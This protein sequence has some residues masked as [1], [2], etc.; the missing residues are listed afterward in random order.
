MS[1]P[2]LGEMRLMPFGF[3]PRGW[4]RCDGGILPINQNTALFSLLGTTYGGNGVSTFQLPDIR[5]RVP[6]GAGTYGPLNFA[7]GQK[8]GEEA[9]MLTAPEVPGHSHA[10]QGVTATGTLPAPDS[11]VFAT[12]TSAIYAAPSAN[13][14]ALPPA[15]VQI[16]G[17]TP[18]PNLQP[19]QVITVAIALAGVWPSRN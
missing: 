7:V 16:V 9:H 1:D 11:N 15:T 3:A 14:V 19:Y 18:H 5:G 10:V 12:V 13:L 17:G 8:G 4:A 6:I 2:F